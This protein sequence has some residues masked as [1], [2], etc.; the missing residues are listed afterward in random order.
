MIN[1]SVTIKKNIF[2]PFIN[3]HFGYI[4]RNQNTLKYSVPIEQA[5]IEYI[6]NELTKKGQVNNNKGILIRV[7][8]DFTLNVYQERQTG[9]W[10]S[11]DKA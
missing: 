1:S 8:E 5:T 6:K 7:Y 4:L 9:S 11:Q 2:G 3:I 10:T